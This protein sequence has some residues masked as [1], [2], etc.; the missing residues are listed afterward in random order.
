MRTILSFRNVL[1]LALIGLAVAL[2]GCSHVNPYFDPAKPHHTPQGFQNN[3]PPNP[4]YQRPQVSFTQSWLNR[5]RNWTS[6]KPE[7]E[8]IRPL[9]P[10][11]P[12]LAFIHGN[13][14]AA[15][16]T[17][18]GHATFLLQTANGLNILTD[19]MFDDR[20][21]P[22]PFAGPKRHQPPGMSIRELP[23]IDA[24]LISHSH[25]D[26][27]SLPSLRAL[28]AQPGGPPMLFVPL[29][30]DVWLEANV[31]GGDRSRIVKLDW[32]D[33]ATIAGTEIHL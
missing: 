7:R 5:I 32:W 2:A 25:Y 28:Y 33:S 17:W 22:L 14:S 20:A 4:A 29:G 3:Y 8:P 1:A 16:L 31:T 26:H 21:S 6:D 19:P 30:I 10:I 15:A 23:R 24:I 11:R 13:K 27:L 9:L 18:I 12:D